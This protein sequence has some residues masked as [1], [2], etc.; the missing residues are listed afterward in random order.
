MAIRFQISD[1]GFNPQSEGVLLKYCA[2]FMSD[3]IKNGLK[4]LLAKI[5]KMKDENE[6][7]IFWSTHEFTDF[8][9]DTEDVDI[10]LEK[11]LKEKIIIRS[12]LA[13]LGLKPDQTTLI[14]KIAHRK[15]VSI[16]EVLLDWI[17][18]GIKLEILS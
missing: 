17:L 12:F 5:P 11:E 1:F 8:L 4:P 2:I 7:D 10:E 6:I 16:K 18:K 3:T 14:E 15:S 9:D 13:T